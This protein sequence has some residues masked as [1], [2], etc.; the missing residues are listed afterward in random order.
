MIK[1]VCIKIEKN[2]VFCYVIFFYIFLIS[3]YRKSNQFRI[4]AYFLKPYA[5]IIMYLKKNLGL[6]LEKFLPRDVS[7]RATLVTN[8]FIVS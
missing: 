5:K 3:I 2:E 7:T 6:K 8:Y 1:K 4:Y